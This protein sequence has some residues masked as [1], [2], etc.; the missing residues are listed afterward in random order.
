[1]DILDLIGI[2]KLSNSEIATPQK[3]IDEM[4][5]LLPD[6]I[7]KPET[8]FLDPA[9]KSGRYLIS[10]KNRLMNSPKMIKAIPD[11]KER[12]KHILENQL[13][14]LAT[15]TTTALITTRAL[16]GKLALNGNVTYIDNYIQRMADKNTNYKDLIKEAFGLNMTFDVVIGNPP[17]NDST[18]R[19]NGGGGNAIYINFIN[20][21]QQIAKYSSLIIPSAW[22]L[23]YPQGCKHDPVDDLR[24]STKFVVLHDFKNCAQVFD[25]VSIPGGVCYY[26]MDTTKEDNVCKH[27]IHNAD[28]TVDIIDNMPLYNVQGNVIFRDKYTLKLLD[29][30]MKI[31]GTAYETFDKNYAGNKDYFDD[32]RE[33]MITTWIGYELQPDDKNNIKYYVNEK[34]HYTEYGYVSFS[35]IPKHSE[36]YKRHKIIIG[37]AFTAGNP[38]VIDIPKHIGNNSVCSQSFIPIF[39]KSNTEQECI[40]IISYM[41]TKFFR[42]LVQSMK[43][44]QHLNTR[45][46]S[47]I[48]VQDFSHTWTDEMLYKKYNLTPEEINYIESTIKPMN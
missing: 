32:G 8:T 47:L 29:N 16:Y 23:L 17:Y 42:F 35:Q 21:G 25:N 7:F 6:E 33:I 10:L 24:K 38:Q 48:P 11:E 9:C 28:N 39:S 19:G 27:Y 2:S 12:L 4:V 20:M 15:S 5:A 37:E 44:D 26:L 22:M 40:N 30:I 46:F 36:D 1:M 13:Y 43:A 31:D 14:G 3:V 34:K 41:K 18:S 45:T